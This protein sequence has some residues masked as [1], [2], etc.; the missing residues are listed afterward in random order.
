M[1]SQW[2]IYEDKGRRSSFNERRPLAKEMG[3]GYILRSCIVMEIELMG[4]HYNFDMKRN[5]NC[6]FLETAV[7]PKKV[8][9]NVGRYDID[10][11]CLKNICMAQY[12]MSIILRSNIIESIVNY[13]TIWNLRC[14]L[15]P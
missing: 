6:D 14:S 9:T 7:H 13:Y 11:S 8:D 3:F 5:V 12:P 15:F 4:N 2:Y 10:Y 1:L